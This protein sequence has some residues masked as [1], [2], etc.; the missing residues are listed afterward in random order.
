MS[1]K[2]EN[3]QKQSLTILDKDY[4]EWVKQLSSR[5]KSYLFKASVHI[6]SEQLKFYYSVGKDIFEKQIDNKYGTKFYATLSR[7]LRKLL[8]D[9]EGLTEGNLRY[10]KRFY[11]L[12]SDPKKLFPQ[13]AEE[14]PKVPWGHHRLLIDKFS[15]N[16]PKALFFVGQIAE[17]WN[18]G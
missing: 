10:A 6:N 14:L 12:Y 9:A 5:Y 13:V 18:R 16:P 3:G 4:L 8:P 1:R 15:D 17:S 11:Q 7:D 2:S